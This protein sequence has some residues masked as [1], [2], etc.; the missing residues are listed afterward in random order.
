MEMTPAPVN[1]PKA[2]GSVLEKRDDVFAPS[3][4]A[5][6]PLNGFPGRLS[7]EKRMLVEDVVFCREYHW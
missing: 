4:I 2:S 3:E 6:F 1:A 5:V 7:A